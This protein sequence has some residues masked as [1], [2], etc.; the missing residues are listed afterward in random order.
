VLRRR[1][2]R[3]RNASQVVQAGIE[4]V[5][6]PQQHGDVEV[7]RVLCEAVRAAGLTDFVLDI[8]HAE[9]A[10]SLLRGLPPSQ[11]EAV[12]EAL[13]AKDAVVL[14]RRAERAGFDSDAVDALVSLVDLHGGKEVFSEAKRILLKTAAYPSL[15]ELESLWHSVQAASLAE[16]VLVDLGEVHRFDYYT[17]LTFQVL[18][19]GP[20]EP[21]AS[22]GRYDTLYQNFGIASA[23]AGFALD[24]HNLCWA[25]EH[26]QRR[27]Q[28]E[29]QLVASARVSLE[30]LTELRKLGIGCCVAEEDA[31]AHAAYWQS[32][33]V[34]QGEPLMIGALAHSERSAPIPQADAV[35]QARA[36]AAFISHVEA[37]AASA[38]G[39]V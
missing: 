11:K 17:G 33:F 27:P 1:K 2:E 6:A 21:L 8:G 35:S 3:A 29:S 13:S 14:E 9:I 12:V 32:A 22:G 25:L 23:A 4:L 38:A 18:A 37:E 19:H 10:A 26:A 24:I 7:V 15:L 30:L 31:V 36:I 16:T 20:G 39:V 34:L 5:G 28:L